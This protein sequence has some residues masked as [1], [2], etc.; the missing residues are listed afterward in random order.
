MLPTFLGIG[1]V[2]SGTNWIHMCIREHPEVFVPEVVGVQ[3]FN[4]NYEKGTAW[5]ESHFPDD[6]A[7]FRAVGEISGEYLADPEAPARMRQLIPDA[8]LFACLRNPIEVVYSWYW[9]RRSQWPTLSFEEALQQH[10]S[11]LDHGAHC[12]QI[13][14]YLEHFPET[15]LLLTLYD[16]LLMD[17]ASFIQRIYR[18]IDVRDDFRPQLLGQSYNAVIFPRLQDTLQRLRMG[19]VKEVVKRTPV[20]GWLRRANRGSR[21]GSYP[22]MDPDTRRRLAER[23]RP[24]VDRLAALLARNLDH[25]E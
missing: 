21:T 12:T 2:R 19:F 25:W 10:P 18:F 15:Q 23:F 8:R 14:R 13:K 24:E 16:D 6:G 1:T 17:D 5:Y 7:P 11:I 4:R 3:F 9:L 22:P 20:T